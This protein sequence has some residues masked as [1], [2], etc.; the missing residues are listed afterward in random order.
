MAKGEP[1]ENF[2]RISH[3]TCESEVFLMLRPAT[4]VL[5]LILCKLRNRYGDKD[6]IFFRSER[7]LADDSGLSLETVSI[8]KQELIGAGLVRWRKGRPW[9]P[10][11][12]QIQDREKC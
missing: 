9:K 5:Y 1:K 4:K 11:L 6:G 12:Y 7:E 2:F 10:S 3:S 8:S